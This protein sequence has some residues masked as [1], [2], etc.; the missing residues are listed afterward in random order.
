M[1]NKVQRKNLIKAA[2][3]LAALTVFAASCIKQEEKV[4]VPLTAAET[5]EPPS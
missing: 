4:R 1:K 2:F 3:L 5:P